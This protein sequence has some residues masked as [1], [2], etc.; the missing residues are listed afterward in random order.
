MFHKRLFSSIL[1]ETGNVIKIE[2][3][4]SERAN[5]FILVKLGNIEDAQ[6]APEGSVVYIPLDRPNS[7]QL[8]T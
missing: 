8:C 3:A 5:F 1:I 2:S 4:R 7:Y 6:N